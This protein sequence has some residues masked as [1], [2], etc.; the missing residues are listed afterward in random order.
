M[1]PGV[2]IADIA[3]VPGRRACLSGMLMSADDFEEMVS[4]RGDRMPD[5]VKVSAAISDDL[6]GLG[7]EDKSIHKTG[8]AVVLS[9]EGAVDETLCVG[10][11]SEA[12]EEV[13]V[14]FGACSIFT[15]TSKDLAGLGLEEIQVKS[16]TSPSFW[17]A[18]GV[19]ADATASEASSCG[20]LLLEFAMHERC[21]GLGS[22]QED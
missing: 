18:R 13:D 17:T 1:L 22:S 15:T 16:T 8:V 14:V 11:V 19:G 7:I 2:S 21:G 6:L 9:R 3:D 4:S 5:G 10:A 12:E 20:L